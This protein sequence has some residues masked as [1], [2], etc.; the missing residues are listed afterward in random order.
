MHKAMCVAA[1]ALL[2]GAGDV[3]AQSSSTLS[4]MPASWHRWDVSGHA[5]AVGVKREDYGVW[6][7]WYESG[8]AGVSVGYF[9]TPNL[10]I[11]GDVERSGEATRTVPYEF[12]VPG[13]SWPYLRPRDHRFQSTLGS[14]TVMYQFYRNRW[15]HPFAGAGVELHYGRE[16][17]DAVAATPEVRGS[18]GSATPAIPALPALDSS[19]STARALVTTGFKVYVSRR[20]F[21]RTDLRL[22]FRGNGPETVTWRGGV[23]IDF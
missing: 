23:G 16:R 3:A 2:M 5:G 6:D 19:S 9:V 18:F 13:Q 11:E 8:L 14:A 21:L 17:A 10:K 4:V 20:A 12:P 22:G 15:F 7:R 1:V